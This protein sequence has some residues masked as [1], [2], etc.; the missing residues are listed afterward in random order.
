M[1]PP[2]IKLLIVDDSDQA[3]EN[4]RKLCR[5]DEDIQVI[6]EAK[7]GKEAVLLAKKLAPDVI[8]MDINM[9]E[10]DGITATELISM[11]IPETSIIMM[12]VQ[13]E[14]EYLRKAMMAGAR[15]YLTKPFSG[16]ELVN[17]IK[18]VHQL[19]TK[20]R[21][22][23]Q[24]AG[25]ER[26]REGRIV[27]IF[28]AKGGVGKTTIATNL[29]VALATVGARVALVDLDLQF[30][31]VALM[32]DLVP[33]RTIADLVEEAE[34]TQEVVEDYLLGHVSGVQVLAAPQRP[35]QAEL[36]SE[37]LVQTVL[38]KLKKSFDYVIVDTAPSFHGTIL[39]ALDASERILLL[40]TLELPSFKNLKL[41]LETM[42]SLQ[43]PE[44]KIAVVVNRYSTDIGI[45]LAEFEESLGTKVQGKV[46][47]DG[48]VVVEA[49]NKGVPFVLSSPKS[50][51]TQALY[52]LVKLVGWQA[53]EQQTVSKTGLFSRLMSGMRKVK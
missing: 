16:D 47:S 52:E 8:L 37:E 22:Q 39:A 51:I 12:S 7:N 19:E 9:P 5:F 53:P 48:R 24:S 41:S 28:S 14:Q 40:G 44:E 10:I 49:V 32:L 3:R 20:R 1:T 13:G 18:R 50:E 33:K 43:Y 2:R 6:G 15:E 38:A 17:T 25:P 29:A 26:L 11:E 45:S 36:V 46:P 4:V 30:G 42:A 34:L 31:D 23:L 27:T 21:Q 35:E